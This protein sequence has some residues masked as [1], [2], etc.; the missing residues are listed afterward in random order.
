[1]AVI[2]L[3]RTHERCDR[4]LLNQFRI[5]RLLDPGCAAL[6]F[7]LPPCFPCCSCGL[8]DALPLLWRNPFPGLRELLP[9]SLT[10]GSR[11]LFCFRL[12]SKASQDSGSRTHVC[13]GGFPACH[14]RMLPYNRS[15]ASVRYCVRLLLRPAPAKLKLGPVY[16]AINSTSSVISESRTLLVESFTIRAKFGLGASA[17][18]SA[19]QIVESSCAASPAIP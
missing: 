10:I 6:G 16:I 18:A 12:A 1:M 19:S 5:R 15:S 13:S 2:Y 3:L 11:Q 4:V 9:N 14:A 17:G 8:R 7:L